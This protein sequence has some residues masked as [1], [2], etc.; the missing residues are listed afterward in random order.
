MSDLGFVEVEIAPHLHSPTLPIY[1]SLGN[2]AAGAYPSFVASQTAW[3][4]LLSF[5]GRLVTSA[6]VATRVAI[7]TATLGDGEVAWR[8]QAGVT[9]T[10]SLTYSYSF[11]AEL[12]GNSLSGN[13]AGGYTAQPLPRQWMPPGTS[14]ELYTLNED[15]GDQW[16]QVMTAFELAQPPDSAVR[17]YLQPH[18]AI[19]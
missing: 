5:H 18:Q 17:H 10:A 8:V 14:F 11:L 6:V 16:S 15:A 1:S 19:S 3:T 4:K 9:Q 12:A 7:V 2:P 13:Q